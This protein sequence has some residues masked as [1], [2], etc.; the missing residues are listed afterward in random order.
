[1]NDLVI[2]AG[3][4]IGMG[5]MSK[6]SFMQID[7]LVEDAEHEHDAVVAEALEQSLLVSL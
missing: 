4:R 2:G 6:K 1:M 5:T 3:Q 7:P